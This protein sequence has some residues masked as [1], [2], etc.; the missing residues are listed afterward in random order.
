M[1]LRGIL[2]HLEGEGVAALLPADLAVPLLLPDTGTVVLALQVVIG[3][4]WR[5]EVEGA[6]LKENSQT[7]I[8]PISLLQKFPCQL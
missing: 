4:R 5:V 2:Q 8:N 1:E 6:N 7:I 3:A